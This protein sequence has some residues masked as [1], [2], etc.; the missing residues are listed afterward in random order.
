MVGSVVGGWRRRRLP[1]IVCRGHR[2]G[3]VQRVGG[4]RSRCV[5]GGGLWRGHARRRGLDVVS[6][7]QEW[8][9]EMLLSA[10]W[11]GEGSRAAGRLTHRVRGGHGEDHLGKRPSDRISYFEQAMPAMVEVLGARRVGVIDT[12][13]C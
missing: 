9:R 1:L 4:E 2:G 6:H 10:G 11:L 5:E 13:T 12:S 3:D 8:M 7:V